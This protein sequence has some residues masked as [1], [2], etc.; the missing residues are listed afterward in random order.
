VKVRLIDRGKLGILNMKKSSS[1]FR[2]VMWICLLPAILGMSDGHWA[3]LQSVAWAK[4]IVQYSRSASIETAIEQ[5]FD[6]QHP[7]AMCKMIQKAQQ[8]ERKQE[9]QQSSFKDDLVFLATYDSLYLDPVWSWGP[10]SDNSTY[11]VRSDPPPVPPPRH[12]VV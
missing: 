12:R 10:E 9:L 11:P 1:I 7:C 5:T 3:L 4:M 6:G 8:S 2:V